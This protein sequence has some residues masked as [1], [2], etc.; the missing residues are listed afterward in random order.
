MDDLCPGSDRLLDSACQIVERG[1]RYGEGDLLQHDAV[2]ALPLLPRR[3]HARAALR[4]REH[5]VAPLQGEAGLHDLERIAGVPGDAH[6]PGVAPEP[7]AETPPH[8]P[9]LRPTPC[10]R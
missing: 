5:F 3:D 4:R 10:P 6:L 2:A 7:A 9:R 8:R 1:G